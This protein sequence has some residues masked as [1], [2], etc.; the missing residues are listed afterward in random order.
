MAGWFAFV[1]H[2]REPLS[3]ARGRVIDAVWVSLDATNAGKI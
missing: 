3:L 2:L 1:A